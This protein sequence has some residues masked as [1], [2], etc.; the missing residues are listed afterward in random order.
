MITFKLFS[1]GYIYCTDLKNGAAKIVFLYFPIFNSDTRFCK[2]TYNKKK[3]R[4]HFKVYVH[5]M[6][7]RNLFCIFIYDMAFVHQNIY[8]P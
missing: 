2:R 4:I 5:F 8:I 1:D 6:L 7:Y 3:L